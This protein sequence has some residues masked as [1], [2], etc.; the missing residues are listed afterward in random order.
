MGKQA[1][2]WCIRPYPNN[3]YRIKEFLK[4]GIAAIGWPDIDDLSG[5]GLSGIRDKVGKSPYDYSSPQAIAQVSGILD[6]F[7]NQ[8]KVGHTIVVP[9][10]T[11]VYFGKVNAPYSF[12]PDFRSDDTG[13]PHW[14]GVKYLFDG[15]AIMR[16]QLP[17]LLFDSLKGRQSVF[18]LPQEEVSEVSEN[19]KR[20]SPVKGELD[21]EAREA[22]VENLSKGTVPGIN[23][24]QF[25]DA[26]RKVLDLYFRGL[27][28]LSTRNGPEGGDS[29]L[30]TELPGGIVVRVQVKCY[31][32]AAGCL[33]EDAIN[34]LRKSMEPGQH[35]IV[36]TTNHVS[37]TAIE[38]AASDSQKP[39]G[40]ID[41]SRFAE[42]VF[43]NLAQL[44]DKDLWSLGLRRAI[45]TR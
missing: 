23:S 33:N 36:V 17:A 7:V 20:Y 30:K 43:E 35:G 44:S 9:D 32:D 19:P 10:G 34:Q 40:I 24:N 14:I 31:Q 28:R 3:L 16:S 4:E 29:D 26:V 12:H 1:Q 21:R 13:Y 5:L 45:A 39:I 42:L 18:A 15:N 8:I 22:Y 38:K 37:E 11:V 2:A 6:R 25:E 27:T 41:V